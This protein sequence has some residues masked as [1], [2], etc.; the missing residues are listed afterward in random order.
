MAIVLT[1]PDEILETL[2]LPKK[3]IEEDLKKELA[4]I[5]YE[6]GFASLGIARRLI[7]MSKWE[8]IEELAKRKIPRHYD[9]KEFKE[10][11]KYAKGCQ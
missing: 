1:I 2:K 8:F 3:Q 10:D 5:L 7:G 11:I 6:R 9:E 4:F